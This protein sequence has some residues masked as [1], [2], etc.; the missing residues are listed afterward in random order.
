MLPRRIEM[1]FF[2]V[3]FLSLSLFVALFFVIVFSPYFIYFQAISKGF[4]SGLLSITPIN[5]AF[6]LK[7]DFSNKKF[8]EFLPENEK[9]WKVFHFSNFEIPLPVENPV[10]QLYPRME[11]LGKIESF[12]G[13]LNNYK[14]VNYFSFI[15]GRNFSFDYPID[16]QKVFTL[17]IFKNFLEA[18]PKEK[19]FELV[20]NKDL[21]IKNLDVTKKIKLLRK[22][23]DI[24]YQE[25][26]INLFIL[27]IRNDIFPKNTKSFSWYSDKGYGVIEL[28]GDNP[29][30]YKEIIFM[31]VK[32]KIY[33]FQWQLSREEL[34]SDNIRFR[35]LNTLK[36][37]KSFPEAFIDAFNNYREL[38]LAKKISS[39]GFTILYS[40]LTHDS[41]NQNYLMAMVRDLKKGQGNE[42]YLQWLY[43]FG[44]RKFKV[45]LKIDQSAIDAKRIEKEK[46]DK[47]EAELRE[48]AKLKTR[49]PSSEDDSSE[50]S[51][52]EKVQI[53]L[54]DAK[55]K[56]EELD[57]NEKVLIEN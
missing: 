17:P 42:K 38:P 54:K 34:L 11:N 7:G 57:E 29:G 36:Y 8:R 14:G 31:L 20:F 10:I 6:I 13:F 51:K 24:S 33:S 16:G 5:Q 15:T 27:Q 2:I 52:E 47:L 12:G 35:F 28:L 9:N 37:K 4:S 1:K 55:E 21:D 26:V 22:L 23:W 46:A 50:V 32:G 43:D 53:F 56:G 30:Q 3:F 45:D 40:G 41:N 18:I 44:L 39:T 49:S 48:A 25:L 19:M